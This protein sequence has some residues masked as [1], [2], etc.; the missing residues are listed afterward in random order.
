MNTSVSFQEQNRPTAARRLDDF[1]DA[2]VYDD[3]DLEEFSEPPEPTQVTALLSRNAQDDTDTMLKLQDN[4]Q[5]R[6]VVVR[7][8]VLT[9]S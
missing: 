9:L 3:D 4:F 2:V 7:F 1:D 6:F 5:K 8:L